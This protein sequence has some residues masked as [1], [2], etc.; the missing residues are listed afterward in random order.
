M[1]TASDIRLVFMAIRRSPEYLHAALASLFMSDPLV[2]QLKGVH[3]VL[4]NA[5]S[6]FLD[7]Y[8]HH[9]RLSIHSLPSEE[10]ARI[11]DWSGL[12][13]IAFNYHRSLTL[14]PRDCAGLCICE[15]DV[16]FHDGFLTDLLEALNEIEA[17]AGVEKYILNVYLPYGVTRMPNGR[18][19]RHAV[20]HSSRRFYGSQCLYFPASTVP[21]IAE[22]IHAEGVVGQCA[23]IDLL[24]GRH[25]IACASLYG[26]SRSLVQHLGFHSSNPGAFFHLAPSFSEDVPVLE[27]F[28]ADR[29]PLQSAP[30]RF[31]L[32][33]SFAHAVRELGWLASSK[34]T[35]LVYLCEADPPTSLIGACD[36]LVRVVGRLVLKAL[37]VSAGG[38]VVLRIAKE[39]EYAGKVQLRFSVFDS[40]NQ[41]SRPSQSA[42]EQAIAD[43]A[44]LQSVEVLKG[45]LWC[46]QRPQGEGLVCHLLA[47]FTYAGEGNRRLADG[48]I[49][50]LR[51]RRIL[52]AAANASNRKLIAL[53][54][55]E[56]GAEAVSVG[57]PEEALR[58]CY[59]A[60]RDRSAY[61]LAILDA[62]MPG[63]D[64]L[65]LARH[66]RGV[67]GAVINIA[68]MFRS[69]PMPEF[70]A[71]LLRAQFG[72]A[73]IGGIVTKPVLRSE[74]RQAL[75]HLI[76]HGAG[77]HSN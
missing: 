65:E 36:L 71:K 50:E 10:A 44:L 15:N 74:L 51:G 57:E 38:A 70:S 66:L 55:A 31:E 3:L 28:P 69:A 49:A 34:G 46:E 8:F 18:P 14:P 22:Y 42:A 11:A 6:Q 67:S 37:T 64:W 1:V 25:S 68:V 56:F 9:R 21:D 75:L 45:R 62:D 77:A 23:P 58:E 5:E 76:H 63:T 54:L 29:R 72:E 33:E 19:L 7:P 47:G 2:H 4:G 24:I 53:L 43:P 26:T 60:S 32:R 13:R 27:P 16:I 41:R 40:R 17:E 59:R 48:P 39:S 61:W 20:R 30:A 73:G 35:E 12:R 52:V